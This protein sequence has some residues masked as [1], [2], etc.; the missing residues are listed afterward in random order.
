[1][2]GHWEYARDQPDQDSVPY[3]PVKLDAKLI[4]HVSFHPNNVGIQ[5][6]VVGPGLPKQQTTAGRY[7][8]TTGLDIENCDALEIAAYGPI[9][10]VPS[11][12]RS[13]VSPERGLQHSKGVCGKTCKPQECT[14]S[15][16]V[17][18]VTRNMTRRFSNQYAP[19]SSHS[20]KHRRARTKRVIFAC[21]FSIEWN[22][23]SQYRSLRK[24]VVPRGGIEP[25]TPAFS[26]QCS[27]N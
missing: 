7:L 5:R 12:R 4:D 20:L 17:P 19:R 16:N 24:M 10:T 15:I 14:C 3:L 13:I 1:M 11:E 2:A 25:P 21:H 9:G 23:L 8:G 26:V 6:I 22:N 27:T 18:R